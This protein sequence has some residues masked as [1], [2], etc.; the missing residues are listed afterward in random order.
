MP[1]DRGTLREIAW[2]ELFPWL[3]LFRTVRPALDPRKL[4]LAAL[5]IVFTSLGWWALGRL[6]EGSD[7]PLLRN[8]IRQQQV[9]PWNASVSAS[10]PVTV[11][12]PAL[13]GPSAY[14]ITEA[15]VP[16]EGTAPRTITVGDLPAPIPIDAAVVSE[17]GP[18][19]FITFAPDYSEFEGNP[20]AQVWQ[21]LTAPFWRL[22]DVRLTLA[23]FTYFLL[24][25]LWGTAVWAFAASAITRIAAVELALEE[26]LSVGSAIGFAR[27]HWVSC[28][29]A[30]VFPLLGVLLAVLFMSLGGWLL[31]FDSTILLLAIIWPL[32]LF[33][34]LVMA[35]LLLGLAFGWPLMWP[36]ISSEGT[37]LFDGISRSYSYV[38]QRP[39]HYVFY[40]FVAAGFGV[41]AWLL[42]SFVGN[43]VIQLSFWGAS[44][45]G[46]A[47]R[48]SEIMAVATGL[49]NES[50]GRLGN[51]GVSLLAFWVGCVRVLTLGFAFSYFWVSSTA[52][53]LLLRRAADAKEMDEVYTELVGDA[54]GLPPLARD[55]AGV[56]MA[57]HE[58]GET[59]GES[60]DDLASPPPEDDG[61]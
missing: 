32:Y 2:R 57:P 53:Y 19:R 35:I 42:V 47:E 5:A 43:S 40:I 8:S 15:G 61:Q 38:F 18:R 26:R 49:E 59:N 28:F 12:V 60:P 9:W 52:I 48:T 33:A 30:P 37:D 41:L 24:C 22:F 1:D 3:I 34:G 31:R 21:S 44:F 36:A 50:F 10:V 27:G 14:L 29:W 6:F 13:N 16:L 56:P 17:F 58:P 23:G 11:A 54:H 45:T 46:G 55:A 25:A 51:A 7:D 20:I 4:L 39:L